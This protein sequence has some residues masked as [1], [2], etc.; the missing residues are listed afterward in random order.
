MFKD[1]STNIINHNNLKMKKALTMVGI[2]AVDQWVRLSP[3]VSGLYR[4]AVMYNTSFGLFSSFGT[5]QGETG[6]SVLPKNKISK[7]TRENSVRIGVNLDYAGKVE[8][9]HNTGLKTMDYTKG[10]NDRIMREQLK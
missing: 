4:N 6:Q 9:I 2:N 10:D 5:M 8:G 3:V 1:Y 7:P